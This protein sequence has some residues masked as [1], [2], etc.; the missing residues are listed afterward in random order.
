MSEN[1]E[2]RSFEDHFDELA[3]D[4]PPPLPKC[5]SLMKQMKEKAMPFHK[6]KKKKK[7]KSRPGY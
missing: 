6:G 5:L 7:K 3:G 4:V 1:E 2:E